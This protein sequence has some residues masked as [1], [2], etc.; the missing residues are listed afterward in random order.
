MNPQEEFFEIYDASIRVDGI[1]QLFSLTA[2]RQKIAFED[3]RVFGPGSWGN[4]GRWTWDAFR[5]DIEK[6][7]WSGSIWYGGTK[8]HDPRMTYL[9]FTHTEYTGGG[10]HFQIKPAEILR[11]DLFFAHKH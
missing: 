6:P 10:I 11:T 3:Y 9:P 4:T 7:K 5:L 2:G 8:I 1:F